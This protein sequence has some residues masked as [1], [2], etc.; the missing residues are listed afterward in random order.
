MQLRQ[1][2]ERQKQQYNQNV[3][4]I[5]Q[6]WQ[7]GEFKKSL[8]LPVLRYGLFKGSQ[9]TTTFTLSLHKIPL[10]GQ[11]VGYLPKGPLPDR[12]LAAALTEIGRE[13][14]CAFIKLEPNILS[15]QAL[16]QI[17][18]SFTPSPKPLFTK[19]NFLLD[20]TP[21]E[22]ELFGNLSPKTRYNVRL[23]QKKG[24]QIEERTDD[25][26][27]EIFLGLHFETTRRQ[28]FHSH[29]EDY[30]RKLWKTLREAGMARLLIGFYQPPATSHRL[31]L[32]AWM[33]YNFKDTLY[34]PYGGSST[35]HK[36]VMASNLV[37]WEAIKLGKKLGLKE[38]DL[39]GAAGSPDPGPADPYYGFHRFK[40]G[41]GAKLVEYVGSF[42]LV[43]NDPLY[44]AFTSIDKFTSLKVLLLKL[45]SK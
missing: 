45:L 20:L 36:E 2:G 40:Q 17:D 41:Y 35:E 27:F 13:H 23:A 22:E 11:V 1:I 34:Y 19:Y 12:Q 9:P 39:W 3:T 26:G 16:Y 8:G 38:F 6:S 4:H 10:S 31:P 42:D 30:H 28:G 44:W 33:L 25:Q 29:N 24:I 7:W 14:N 15:S 43:F 18:P 32:S 37:A 5:I 21:S